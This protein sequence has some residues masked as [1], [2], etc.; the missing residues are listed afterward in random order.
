MTA[1]SVASV[2]ARLG[3]LAASADAHDEPKLARVVDWVGR[4]VAELGVERVLREANGADVL[5]ALLAGRHDMSAATAAAIV[6]AALASDA[7]ALEC[8][9]PE[10][11]DACV[12][13]ARA[14]L[15]RATPAAWR[16]VAATHAL[17][18]A[19]LAR[20]RLDRAW[21]KLLQS[22][23]KRMDG[24]L[25]DV[26]LWARFD[27]ACSQAARQ[28]WPSAAGLLARALAS[29][30]VEAW[31]VSAF[32]ASLAEGEGR[33]LALVHALVERGAPPSALA[34]LVA[35][36]HGAVR[37]RPRPLA[38]ADALRAVVR[39]A[40]TAALVT[41]SLEALLDGLPGAQPDAL[42]AF[43]LVLEGLALAVAAA[44]APLAA[45]R[46]RLAGLAAALVASAAS[47]RAA[48]PLGLLADGGDA[49]AVAP[50]DAWVAGALHRAEVRAAAGGTAVDGRRQLLLSSA[51]A[52]GAAGERAHGAPLAAALLRC[53]GGGAAARAVP[54]LAGAL[55]RLAVRCEG[56]EAAAPALA[57]LVDAG[58]A[59]HA[60]LAVDALVALARARPDDVARAVDP[61]W[62]ANH[63]RDARD[64]VR[65]GALALAA[66]LF[67]RLGRGCDAR[68]A[69]LE[70]A[71]ERAAEDG[72]WGVRQRAVECL[73]AARREAADAETDD[74]QDDERAAVRA[75]TDSEFLVRR[76]GIE[77]A[78]ALL[79][80]GAAPPRAT[81][82]G[83]LIAALGDAAAENRA[84]AA[85]ALAIAGVAAARAAIAEMA[86]SSS[87]RVARVA[88]RAALRRLDGGEEEE[89]AEE[90][91]GSGGDDD[92]EALFDDIHACDNALD[93]Y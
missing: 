23:W 88:A 56:C 29:P 35:P 39:S 55:A 33:A 4:R 37:D 89:E 92:I 7:D 20:R 9:A 15:E 73:V 72:E 79:L 12:A 28:V 31:L 80:R 66:A 59:R 42:R 50:V 67:A 82:Q 30:P 34:P 77:L 57:T 53:A 63:A 54:A 84:A 32:G 74:E 45:A 64:E 69:V 36:L 51:G 11:L 3:P 40:G 68:G 16:V 27:V 18:A 93:C 65:E 85:R 52:L 76:G 49:A 83:A 48:S 22:A 87:E 24:P 5:G 41:P 86:A 43:G 60:T 38:A 14:D 17:P 71:R 46:A 81:L 25:L 26:R 2:L 1:A 8:V 6:G 75:L 90:E 62:L 78:G 61:A 70:A 13:L 44:E 91:A 21:P 47:A 19:S 58:D 10:L